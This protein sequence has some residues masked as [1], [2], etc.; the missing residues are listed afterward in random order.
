MTGEHK[1]GPS[2]LDTLKPEAEAGT[3][4]TAL[5]LQPITTQLPIKR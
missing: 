1:T 3:I 5:V 4:D 2:S